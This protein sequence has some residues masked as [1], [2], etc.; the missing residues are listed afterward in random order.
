MLGMLFG[1]VSFAV[2]AYVLLLL[3]LRVAAEVIGI[4]A[5]GLLLMLVIR[6]LWRA[7]K[8]KPG[9]APVGALSPDER[10]KAQAKLFRNRANK[11]P[12]PDLDLG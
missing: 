12:G 9:K 10:I 1:A 11:P 5:G 6:G 7:R 3:S 4:A 8:C 2:A